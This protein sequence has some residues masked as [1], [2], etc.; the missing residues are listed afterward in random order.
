M[1]EAEMMDECYDVE[2]AASWVEDNGYDPD[3]FDF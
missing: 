1:I 3:D 2:D